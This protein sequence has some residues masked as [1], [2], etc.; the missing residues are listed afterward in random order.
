MQDR[1]EVLALQVEYR[2]HLDNGR[3]D[4][5][6]RIGTAMEPPPP[7]RQTAFL[8]ARDVT[9]ERRLGIGVDHRAD[10]G[11]QMFGIADGQRLEPAANHLQHLVIDVVLD[12]KDAERRAAL[13][14][15]LEGA[16]NDVARDL[17]GQRGGIDDHR[18]LA[19]SLCD[20]RSD[21][22]LACGQTAVD[23]LCGLR[24]TGESNPR[25]A[26]IGGD[27]FADLARAGQELE[28]F[29][30]D[31]RLVAQAH[32]QRGDQGGL[33]G[34][35]GNHRIARGK[36]RGRRSDEDRQ[37]EIPRADTGEH[38]TAMQAQAIFLARWARKRDRTG[39]LATRFIGVEAQEVDRFAQFE[40]RVQKRLARF[41]LAQA[42]ELVG[43]FLEQVGRRFE[44][45]RAFFAA[46]PI[47]TGLDGF[48]AGDRLLDLEIERIAARADF[49]R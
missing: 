32:R 2:I 46:Q 48:G 3:R 49:G 20:Q 37:R 21:R 23:G 42:Q 16:G 33:F 12:I 34:R 29:F 31:P 8:P 17:F 13:S 41:A 40:H 15:A 35:L 18:V 22:P 44:Q 14:R 6:A 4:E 19:A 5:A 25:D 43:V 10:I 1:A 7:Y 47:P 28:R 39:E 27:H 11:R 30:G 38:P 24:R 45:H 36:C 26:R 9:F